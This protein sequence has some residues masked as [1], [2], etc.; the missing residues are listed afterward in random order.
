M[1]DHN[2]DK[3]NS[4]HFNIFHKKNT[5]LTKSKCLI[6]NY[7]NWAYLDEA[8]SLSHLEVV[9]P[10]QCGSETALKDH[11]PLQHLLME[12]V[13]QPL[14]FSLSK[15]HLHHVTHTQTHKG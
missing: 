8:S 14:P 9:P 13:L 7:G 12:H 10:L 15:E 11:Y 3:L 2:I 6:T 4:L 5:N 1:N